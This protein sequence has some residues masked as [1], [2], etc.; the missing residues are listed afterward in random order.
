[1]GG[2]ERT[3]D[4]DRPE[5]SR[6]CR[7]CLTKLIRRFQDRDRIAAEVAALVERLNSLRIEIDSLTEAERQVELMKHKAAE[8]AEAY[9]LEREK[10][11]AA[12]KERGR[13]EDD[14]AEAHQRLVNLEK[15][16]DKRTREDR[17]SRCNITDCN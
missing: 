2:S 5:N 1:M 9:A 17:R 4:F 3:P 14:I 12:V 6:T 16:I 13:I 15:Q 8:A 11:N 10:I 7:Y